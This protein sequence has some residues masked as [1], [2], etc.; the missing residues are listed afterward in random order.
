MPEM[1]YGVRV[2]RTVREVFDLDKENGNALWKE[3]I[4]KELSALL[5]LDSNFLTSK[6]P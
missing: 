4:E 6:K 3:S 5:L 1:K 2:P